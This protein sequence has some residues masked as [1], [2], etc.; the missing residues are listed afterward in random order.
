MILSHRFHRFSQTKRFT[1]MNWYLRKSFCDN[2]F[3]CDNLCNL[4]LYILLLDS[5]EDSLNNTL[6]IGIG[7]HRPR[8]KTEP[9]VEE[10][11]TNAI[12]IGR[13]IAIDGLTVHGL[14]KRTRL[15]ASLI[16]RHAHSLNIPVRFTVRMYWTSAMNLR[17][18]TTDGTPDRL[19]VGPL[20]TFHF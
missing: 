19:C 8:G 2:H 20:F 11:L 14:P 9:S 3:F 7:D 10:I 12:D 17:R 18:S 15:D 6:D 4:W 1:Q 16:E 13:R 5:R